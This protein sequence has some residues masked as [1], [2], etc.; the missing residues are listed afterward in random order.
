MGELLL[1]VLVKIAAYVLWPALSSTH[2]C[3]TLSKDSV[4]QGWDIHIIYCAYA[5]HLALQAF[6]GPHA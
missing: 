2:Q 6:H 4:W 1:V 3:P 5:G